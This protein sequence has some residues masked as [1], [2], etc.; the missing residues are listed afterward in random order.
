MNYAATAARDPRRESTSGI[1]RR[2]HQRAVVALAQRR[3]RTRRRDGK[4]HLIEYDDH[5]LED[6][7]CF[8]YAK[9][10]SFPVVNPAIELYRACVFGSTTG[11]FMRNTSSHHALFLGRLCRAFAERRTADACHFRGWTFPQTTVPAVSGRRAVRRKFSRFQCSQRTDPAGGTDRWRIR[12]LACS[13]RLIARGL[14]PNR[15]V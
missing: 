8:A 9:W 13:I 1:F 15:C 12:R 4:T 11:S 7:S 14:G 5:W 10:I 3:I 2:G 6:G